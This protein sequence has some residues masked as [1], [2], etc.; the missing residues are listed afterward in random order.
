M[1]SQRGV[2]AVA[3]V[4]CDSPVNL[5]SLWTERVQLLKMVRTIET[6]YS[7]CL[8]WWCSLRRFRCWSSILTFSLFYSFS[9][10]RRN[11]PR[12]SFKEQPG[13]SPGK[14]LSEHLCTTWFLSLRSHLIVRITRTTINFIS[15][16]CRKRYRHAKSGCFI[17]TYLQYQWRGY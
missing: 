5:A 4:M 7:T 6:M 13:V 17:S 16:H 8:C 15:V 11:V 10:Y 9:Y 3:V 2:I 14:S 12:G 1:I